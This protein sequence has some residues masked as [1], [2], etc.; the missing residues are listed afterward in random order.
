MYHTGLELKDWVACTVHTESMDSLLVSPGWKKPE[1]LNLSL[2]LGSA[3]W[4]SQYKYLNVTVADFSLLFT[5]HP[6]R[7]T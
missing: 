3:Q 2:T 1:V 7:H 5:S 6:L 4:A